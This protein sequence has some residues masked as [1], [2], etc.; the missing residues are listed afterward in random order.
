MKIYS[1][2]GINDFVVCLGYTVHRAVFD[3]V[4]M[5]VTFCSSE[6]VGEP[7]GFPDWW[8]DPYFVFDELCRGQLVAHFINAEHSEVVGRQKTAEAIRTLADSG[9]SR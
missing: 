3:L 5:R 4:D 7:M 8:V 9:L 1:S 6:Q 2:H